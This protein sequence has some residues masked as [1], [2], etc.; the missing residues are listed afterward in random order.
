MNK[1]GSARLV[2]EHDEL[3]LFLIAHGV[4]PSSHG[5]RAFRCTGKV[6]N[7]HAFSHNERVYR[8]RKYKD[9]RLS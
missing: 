4:D 2:T 6:R 3:H 1:L 7:E 5:N 9:V 8:W